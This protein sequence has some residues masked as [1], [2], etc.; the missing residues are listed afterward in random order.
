MK[1]VKLSDDQLALIGASASDFPQKFSAFI[2]EFEK[3][4]TTM[5]DPNPD[6]AALE[7]RVLTLERDLLQGITR[8]QSLETRPAPLAED[9]I[10]AVAKIEASRVTAEALA[11]IGTTPVKPT[12][13]AADLN[14]TP[15][16]KAKAL[17]KAG[18]FEEAYEA[19]PALR[20]EFQNAKEF[21]AYC[22]AGRKGAFRI[23]QRTQPT[24]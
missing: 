17:I 4:K 2:A 9:A 23:S 14:E 12:P 7:K 16:A 10:K 1:I 24:K 19:N 21:A 15:E 18:K 13:A 5:A 20:A 22:R 8:I 6:Y 11:A 3:N